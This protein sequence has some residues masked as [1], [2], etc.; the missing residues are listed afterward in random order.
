L[1]GHADIVADG[2]PV[3]FAKRATTVAMIALVVLQRGGSMSREAL[4]FLLFPDSDESAALAELRR[5]IYLAGKALPE[6]D[7]DPWLIVDAETVRWNGVSGAF[8]DVLAFERF[9][10]DPQTHADAI[11]LYTGDLLEGVYDDWTVAERERLRTRYLAILGESLERF[12]AKRDFPAALGAA[13]RILAT[14]PWREDVLRALL[15]IRYEAGDTAGALSEYERFAKRLRDELDVAPMPETVAVRASI[16]RGDLVPGGARS[17][18]VPH[19][20]AVPRLIAQLPFVGRGRELETLRAAWARAACGA[21]ALLILSGEAGVGKTRLTAELARIVQAEGGRVFIGT[22]ATPE[23]MPYQ[24]IVDALRSALPLLAARPPPQARRAA[25]ARLLPELRDQGAPAVRLP[26]ESS[27]R[28]SA[29]LYDAL[30]HSI[31]SLAAPRPLLLILEDLQWAGPATIDALGAV[32]RELARTPVLVVATCRDDETPPGHPLRSL[33]RALQL[34]GGVDELLVER[35]A[36]RDVAALV[37]SIEELAER[38]GD[39]AAELYAQSEGNALFLSEAISAALEGDRAASALESAPFSVIAMRLARLGDEARTIA[40]IAAI[41]GAGCSVAAIHEVSNLPP[42]AVAR[43]LDE[44]LERRLLREA[45]ARARY[46]YAFT[47]HLIAQAVYDQIEPAFRAQRHA[48]FG[49]VLEATYYDGRGENAADIARH[50]ERA[51]DAARSATWYLV[52]ARYASSVNAHGDAVELASRAMENGTTIELRRDALDARE[53]ANGRRGD[54]DAQRADIDELERLAGDDAAARFDALARRVL[55]ARSL[56]TSEEEGRLIELLEHLG[57]TLDDG[58]RAHALTQ[59]AT[60]AGLRS[61]PAEGLAPA[62]LALELYERL[63]NVPGQLECL[64]LLVEFAAN[65]GD[66]P[67]SRAYLDLMRERARSLSDRVL[68]A[69]AL[70]VAAVAALLRQDYAECAD[71]TRRGLALNVAMND[72]EG[73]AASRGRLAVTAAWLGDFG[74][75]LR[76]FA[77]ATSSYEAIG[78]KRG[79]ALTYTNR[80]LLLMRLGSFEEALHSIERSNALFAIANEQRTVVANQVNESFVRL[81]LGDASA[82]RRLA[83]AALASAREIGFPLFEA[84]AF[85]NI[86]NAELALGERDNAVAHM[87][88]GIALRRPLQA[89]REFVDDLADLTLAYVAT[90][91]REEALTLARELDG[92]GA[93]AFDGALWPHYIRWATAQGFAAGEDEVRGRAA[94]ARARDELSAFAER[95]EDAAMRST[96]LT[97]PIN[98]RIAESG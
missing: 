13:N 45:G 26:P 48:R 34:Y 73:E 32:V 62:R 69:R 74:T 92:L 7:G 88:A 64:F 14:D 8:V 68:E 36:M 11:A 83:E 47:H 80:T 51:G 65:M 52:A 98:R 31:R 67:S 76:E 38:G 25:L 59:R 17:H 18:N 15:A 54:R 91:R 40:E 57:A 9:A 20:A 56:G 10:S 22:T 81:Q 21:G 53:K 70:A 3:K 55:L 46:D 19:D 24:A 79:L 93:A 71:L 72:R 75:A 60:H 96:F 63:E 77:A 41:A 12:R 87:E 84:A 86:G 89:A 50:Y 82:A 35:L 37:A 28:E 66:L 5:Y 90:D 23:A 30:V 97:L 42:T 61:R 95:I 6:R 16:V 49:R 39:V 2:V 85:A 94:R 4:A 1:F 33:Q 27:E 44:L 78:N 29:R 43:G 58:A